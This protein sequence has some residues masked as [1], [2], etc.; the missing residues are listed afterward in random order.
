LP[1]IRFFSRA[2]TESQRGF[3][4]V[5]ALVLA[6]LYFMLMGLVMIDSSRAQAEAQRYRARVV[7]SALAENAAELACAQM[8]NLPSGMAELNDK[9]GLMRG[10]YH[11]I[12]AGAPGETFEVN[13]EAETKG[14]LRLKATVFLEGH[15]E[16]NV[17][18]IDY[19][20]HS[21]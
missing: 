12:G 20:R 13:G 5:I 3:V 10:A 16:G 8:V 9:Q 18:H 19:A 17:I 7:A 2:R 4:L 21:Q 11:R 6:I 14:L 15:F 1:S